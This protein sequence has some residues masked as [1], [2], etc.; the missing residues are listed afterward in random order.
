MS[1]QGLD[2]WR[3]FNTSTFT[4]DVLNA[5]QDSLGDDWELWGVESFLRHQDIKHT[6][7]VVW[8]RS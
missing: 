6:I 7:K 3:V 4:T 2:R 5:M 1:E 8:K